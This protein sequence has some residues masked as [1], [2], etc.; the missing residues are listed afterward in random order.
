MSLASSQLPT[1]RDPV[2]PLRKEQTA[3]HYM[4]DSLVMVIMDI[5]RRRFK[6]REIWDQGR[7]MELWGHG[8]SEAG[9]FGPGGSRPSPKWRRGDYPM[10]RVEGTLRSCGMGLEVGG[11][12]D[13]SALGRPGLQRQPALHAHGV[14]GRH[15]VADCRRHERTERK[16]RGG[17]PRQ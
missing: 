13:W 7:P 9:G 15:L 5:S 6:S 4:A 16:R 2:R 8:R 10:F 3:K 14:H 1:R 12:G 11:R 17:G